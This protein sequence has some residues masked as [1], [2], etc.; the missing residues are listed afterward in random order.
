MSNVVLKGFQKRIIPQALDVPD[1]SIDRF[2][3]NPKSEQF[4]Q[5]FIDENAVALTFASKQEK[6]QKFKKDPKYNFLYDEQL[7]PYIDNIDYFRNS[8]SKLESMLH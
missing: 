8:G 1:S 3:R 5:G 7:K 2:F 6:T 4:K